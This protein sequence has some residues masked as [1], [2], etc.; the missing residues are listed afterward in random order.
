M[1]KTILLLLMSFFLFKSAYSQAVKGMYVNDFVNIVGDVT[2]END[3]L[4][5]AQANGYNYLILYNLYAIHN[6][7]FDITDPI[8]SQPLA[9]F[10]EKARTLYGITQVAGVGETYSSFTNIHDYNLDHAATPNQQLDHYNIEFEFW[11]SGSVG[12]EGYYCT[13]YLEPL[14]LP[15]DTS[16]SFAFLIDNLCDL[17][18]LCDDFA[19][20]DSEMY[21]GWPN[22]GQ[23]KQIADCTDRLLVHY[24]RGSDVYMTGNSIY[25]YGVDRLPDLAASDDLSVVMPIFNC[26]PD[27]MGA[28][29]DANPENQAF[30]TW[31]NGL[32]GYNDAVGSWKSNTLVDGH[33]WFKYTCMPA[34]VLPVNLMYFS[35]RKIENGNLLSWEIEMDQILK[36]IEIERASFVNAIHFQ[37]ITT[38]KHPYGNN[39]FYLDEDFEWGTNVYRL[40]FIFADDTYEYSHTISM[41]NQLERMSISCVYEEGIPFLM[42]Q[43]PQEEMV[44]ARVYNTKGQEIWQQKL[45]LNI[46]ENKLVLPL[47]QQA[48]G[49]YFVALT[50]N[51]DQQLVKVLLQ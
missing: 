11:N 47:S 41:D 51:T 42:I 48:A 21:I 14:G 5:Q 6:T 3:L 18:T 17:H 49:I 45:Q 22:A 36:E 40:K 4:I 37:K 38:I 35:G 28:W 2:A 8:T 34:G 15:C 20:I 16:G 25:N 13:T 32:N 23:A 29:L 10:I 44:E 9:D 1:K 24:Y 31:M 7:L 30:D 26:Q 46:G 33:V 43:S 19:Y 39:A 12:D 50:M 27:Y